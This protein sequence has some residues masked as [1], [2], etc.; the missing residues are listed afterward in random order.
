MLAL[1]IIPTAFLGQKGGICI[2]H[3]F[4]LPLIF[5][6]NCPE[7]GIF[8][9]CYCPACGLTHATSALLHGQITEAYNFNPLVF[10]T[11][12]L[13]LFL[14]IYNLFKLRKNRS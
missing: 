11:T 9:H 1:A 14:L 6:D 10:I 12:P 4:I 2:W 5:K 13:I 7:N 8:S 3:N